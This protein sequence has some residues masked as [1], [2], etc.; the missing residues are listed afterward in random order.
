MVERSPCKLQ[1]WVRIRLGKRIFM[2]RF[3]HVVFKGPS[4]K[5]SEQALSMSRF[6]LKLITEV[7]TGHCRTNYHLSKIGVKENPSCDFCGKAE[8][9]A[10]HFLCSCPFLQLNRSQYFGS[11]R[12]SPDKIKEISL[13]KLWSYILASKR[14][15]TDLGDLRPQRMSDGGRG[16]QS[17]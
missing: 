12:V 5:L 8:E 1:T 13:S 15:V 14:F 16:R 10:E 17:P 3:I 11:T 2:K 4:R 7:L 9:T 6:R